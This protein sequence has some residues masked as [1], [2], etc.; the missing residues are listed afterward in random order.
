MARICGDSQSAAGSDGLSF[1][2]TAAQG[3]PAHQFDLQVA[4]ITQGRIYLSRCNV[5]FTSS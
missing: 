2:F 4:L 5:R 1:S 3:V